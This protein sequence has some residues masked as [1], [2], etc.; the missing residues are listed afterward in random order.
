MIPWHSNRAR[1]ELLDGLVCL[2]SLPAKDTRVGIVSL[3]DLANND[4]L[5]LSARAFEVE[6][7]LEQV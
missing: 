4:R 1:A 2:V 6:E 5:Q 7:C 3:L